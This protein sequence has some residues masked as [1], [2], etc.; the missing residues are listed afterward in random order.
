MYSKDVKK[1]THCH[2]LVVFQF[3]NIPNSNIHPLFVLKTEKTE[4]QR[5]H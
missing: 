3:N 2:K 5:E 4:Q 1:N